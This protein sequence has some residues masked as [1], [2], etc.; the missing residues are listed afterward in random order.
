[1][2]VRAACLSA[3]C[4][5]VVTPVPRARAQ[6]APPVPAVYAEARAER[7]GDALAK[8]QSLQLV[9]VVEQVGS[10]R[11][12]APGG[13]LPGRMD[14][15]PPHAIEQLWIAPPGRFLETVSQVG[16]GIGERRAGLDG[17]RVIGALSGPAIHREMMR[18]ALGLM[19]PDPASLTVTFTDL[20]QAIVDGRTYSGVRAVGPDGECLLMFDAKQRLA[21]TEEQGTFVGGTS[22][23]RG[24]VDPGSGAVNV[25]SRETDSSPPKTVLYRQVYSDFKRVDGVELPYTIEQDVAGNRTQLWHLSKVELNPKDIDKAFK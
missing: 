25:Q 9:Y 6:A 22:H 8:V 16:S 21:I 14:A 18:F 10:G 5:F 4:L 23:T 13:G 17:D 1:M 11:V 20:G 7:G 12:N 15:D 3:V 24:T 2:P 19:L